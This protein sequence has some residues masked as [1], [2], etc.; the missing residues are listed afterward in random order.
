MLEDKIDSQIFL[1]A[2]EAAEQNGNRMLESKEFKKWA[3][4]HKTR[5]GNWC[6]AAFAK[7]GQAVKDQDFF[8]TYIATAKG[9]PH[10]KQ[11]AQFENYLKDFTPSSG[12]RESSRSFRQLRNHGPDSGPQVDLQQ[13]RPVWWRS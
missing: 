9:I 2:L 6:K 8:G 12:S 3:K 5:L 4:G 10:F 13:H 7:G 1:M 11:L